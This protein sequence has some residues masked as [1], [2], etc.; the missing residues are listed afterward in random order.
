[1]ELSNFYSYII[2]YEIAIERYERTVEIR[3]IDMSY[4]IFFGIKLCILSSLQRTNFDFRRECEMKISKIHYS[5]GALLISACTTLLPLSFSIDCVHCIRCA[6]TRERNSTCRRVSKKRK[7]RR[8]KKN[9]RTVFHE[10]N[11][12]SDAMRLITLCV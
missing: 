7:K 12:W 2:L 11:T 6:K 4:V 9:R 8:K 10:T 3:K 1:M 5:G